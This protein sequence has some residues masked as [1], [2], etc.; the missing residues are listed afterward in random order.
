MNTGSTYFFFFDRT[1]YHYR[2]LGL[3]QYH[4]SDRARETTDTGIERRE[5]FGISIAV[6]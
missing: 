3:L 1:T 6:S 2:N 4:K 5:V